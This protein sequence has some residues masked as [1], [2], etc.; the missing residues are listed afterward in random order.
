MM[1][2][3]TIHEVPK[4]LHHTKTLLLDQTGNQEEIED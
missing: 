3:D 1:E 2:A 4:E